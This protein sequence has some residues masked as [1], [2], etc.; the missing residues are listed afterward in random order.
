MDRNRDV[1]SDAEQASKRHAPGDHWVDDRSP[2]L[3]QYRTDRHFVVRFEIPGLD[4]VKDIDVEVDGGTLRIRA[5][6]T[7]P[8]EWKGAENIASE[9]R[10]G[11]FNRAVELP[12]DVSSHHVAASYRDGVLDVHL[13]LCDDSA[14][15][16][17]VAVHRQ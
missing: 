17:H 10:Y 4:P 1:M 8:Y 9:F 16:V 15:L 7:E 11:T 12:R 13:P 6:R 14:D 5:E 3:E 2:A